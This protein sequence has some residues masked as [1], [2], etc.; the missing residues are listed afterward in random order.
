MTNP[1]KDTKDPRKE[2]LR[3]APLL[4]ID[5]NSTAPQGYT[6]I[7][8]PT[9]SKACSKTHT[10]KLSITPINHQNIQFSSKNNYIH[11]SLIVMYMY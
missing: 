1:L 6:V 2:C 8:C 11:L 7:E 4:N 9:Q 10:C 5:D 3:K